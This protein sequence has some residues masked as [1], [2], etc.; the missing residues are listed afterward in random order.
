MSKQVSEFSGRTGHRF[1]LIIKAL[2][3]SETEA[4]PLD[5]LLKRLERLGYMGE[6]DQ[7]ALDVSNLVQRSEVAFTLAEGHAVYWA[8]ERG[9]FETR[10][11]A[12][13]IKLHNIEM[14]E[15]DLKVLES[16]ARKGNA[17]P[18]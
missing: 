8:L 13:L 1:N 5:L 17:K 18:G 4:V 10:K 12:A 2:P 7:L 15:E 6:L 11:R 3:R 14:T 9:L 16:L